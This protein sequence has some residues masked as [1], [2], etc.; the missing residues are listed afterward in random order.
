M[1]CIIL[2]TAEFLCSS[3]MSET[4]RPRTKFI[5]TTDMST[6]NTANRALKVKS[7]MKC[8][9]LRLFFIGTV[10]QSKY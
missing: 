7:S 6:T 5:R 3:S 4:A 8:V 2:R 9:Y 1:T 10:G